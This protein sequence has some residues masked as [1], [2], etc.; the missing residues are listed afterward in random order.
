MSYTNEMLKD[1]YKYNLCTHYLLPLTGINMFSFGE[2]NFVECY[3]HPDGEFIYVKIKDKQQCKE[4][5]F[6]NKFYT[7]EDEVDLYPILRYRLPKYFLN[8]FEKF[9][10]GKY[11]EF[12]EKAKEQ[13]KKHS[14]LTYR[15]EVN[16]SI[17][18]DTDARLAALDKLDTLRV[19][20]E[21]ELGCN[22]PKNVELMEKPGADNFREF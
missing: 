4:E 21:K 11:S 17:E 22:I 7:G 20:L 13:L 19:R 1:V 15:Q 12:S 14:G 2:E 18:P 16:G 9:R 6:T 8:D 3:A 5:A 10:E